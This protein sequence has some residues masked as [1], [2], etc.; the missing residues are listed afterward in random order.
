MHLCKQFNRMVIIIRVNR[1]FSSLVVTVLGFKSPIW[2]LHRYSL[3]SKLSKGFDFPFVFFMIKLQVIHSR[4]METFLLVKL[5]SPKDKLSCLWNNDII[6]TPEMWLWE[7]LCRCYINLHRIHF[8]YLKCTTSS[9]FIH[10]DF[11][12]YKCTLETP[13]N[14][15]HSNTNSDTTWSQYLFSYRK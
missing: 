15:F 11:I 1:D 3:L 5:H 7:V 12:H 13:N 14:T 2:Q 6:Q 8:I 4:S 10:T 9:G